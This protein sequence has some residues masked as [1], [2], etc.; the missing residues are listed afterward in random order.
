MLQGGS[1]AP[2]RFKDWKDILYFNL[3]I[4]DIKF[5]ANY[6]RMKRKIL[7]LLLILTSFIGYLEWGGHNQILLFQAEGE[8]ISKLFSDPAS[9]IHPFT[10]LPMIGQIILLVTLFQDKPNKMMTYIGI[11]CLG[12]LLGFMLVIG[13]MSFNYKI[14]LSTLPFLIVAVITILHYKNLKNH[15]KLL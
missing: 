14:I 10:L 3:N 7:N 13:L 9:V 6:C 4:I 15:S 8:I 12:L 1:E 5:E 11:S 2:L